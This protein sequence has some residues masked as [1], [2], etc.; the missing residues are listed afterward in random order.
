[1]I[2]LQVKYIFISEETLESWFDEKY[3]EVCE[4]AN[5][6]Q[7]IIVTMLFDYIV[8]YLDYIVDIDSRN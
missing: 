7:T 1:M 5:I 2:K 3:S 8:D 6:Y 4:I